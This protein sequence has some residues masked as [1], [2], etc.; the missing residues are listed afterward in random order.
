[1]VNYGQAV[2]GLVNHHEH[3]DVDARTVFG[4]VAPIL[5]TNICK[6]LIPGCVFHTQL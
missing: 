3:M 5:K 4:H 6:C 1:V 2:L